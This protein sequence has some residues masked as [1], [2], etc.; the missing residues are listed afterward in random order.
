M[1]LEWAPISKAGGPLCLVFFREVR[2]SLAADGPE[3][4][5]GP[6]R[7]VDVPQLAVRG[8]FGVAREGVAGGAQEVT[9][10]QAAERPSAGEVVA[11]RDLE[12]RGVVLLLLE[13]LAK[14]SH[15]SLRQKP[16]LFLSDLAAN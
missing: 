8:R 10:G 1:S 15:V 9:A 7:Q 13:S 11:H 2:V 14:K 6:G 12:L 4:D 16:G 5:L 3:V